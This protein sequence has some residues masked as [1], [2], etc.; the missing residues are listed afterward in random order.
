MTSGNRVEIGPFDMSNQAK[1]GIRFQTVFGPHKGVKVISV[2]SEGL[3]AEWNSRHPALERVVPGVHI[4]DWSGKT[5]RARDLF[6]AIKA[7][8]SD[9]RLTLLTGPRHHLGIEEALKRVFHLFDTDDS[10]ELSLEEFEEVA[11]LVA[12]EVGE[13]L[14]EDGLAVADKNGDGT[15]SLDE[16]FDYTISM[17]E[18][19]GF[20]IDALELVLDGLARRQEQSRDPNAVLERAASSRTIKALEQLQKGRGEA[21][22][23]SDGSGDEA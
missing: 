17:F 22:E 19:A 18:S 7:K 20:D 3:I 1:L 13:E 15:L 21:I 23:E 6:G 8:Q 2:K 14:D 5:G 4:L 12:L 10:G 16:F 11:M 9:L